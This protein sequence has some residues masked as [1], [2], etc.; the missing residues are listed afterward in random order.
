MPLRL[1]FQGDDILVYS[2]K[3]DSILAVSTRTGAVSQ[4]RGN[5]ELNEDS[6]A[7]EC[8][9]G[10]SRFPNGGYGYL[11]VVLASSVVAISPIDQYKIHKV[12]RVAL[13]PIHPLD[14]QAA[15]DVLGSSEEPNGDESEVEDP[16]DIVQEV[17]PSSNIIRRMFSGDLSTMDTPRT[18]LQKADSPLAN[19][20][21]NAMHALLEGQTYFSRS[22]LLQDPKFRYNQHFMKDIPKDFRVRLVQGF[23]RQVTL[24][25]AAMTLEVLL[26]SM[27]SRHRNGLRYQRRGIDKSGHVANFVETSQITWK[28]DTPA[29]LTFKQI[30]GS[31]PLHWTQESWSLHPIPL[32]VRSDEV[33]RSSMELHYKALEEKYNRVTS[34]SLVEQKGREGRVGQAFTRRM[35]HINRSLINYDFHHETSGMDYSKL[36]GL[37]DDIGQQLSRDAWST[38]YI[39]DVLLH[40][41]PQHGIIRTNC[42]DCLDRTNVVQS[43]IALAV[44]Q[45]Q[46]PECIDT[47]EE[48]QATFQSL[49]AD[50]G[51][52]IA[53]QYTN[54]PALKGDFTRTGKR[55]LRG[56]LNDARNA[57]RRYYTN[58]VRDFFGQLVIDHL[59]GVVD[60]RAVERFEASLH[61]E[62]MEAIVAKQQ[63]QQHALEISL[64]ILLGDDN[65]SLGAWTLLSP[66]NK[67]DLLS[68]LR[69]RQVILTESK[70]YVCEFD[71]DLDRVAHFI[72]IDL[73]DISRIRIG[74]YITSTVHESFTNTNS[75]YGFVIIYT[76]NIERMV[77]FKADSQPLANH[78]K[79]FIEEIVRVI[80]S[81]LNKESSIV[82]TKDVVGLDAHRGNFQSIMKIVEH[83]V[84]SMIW[85]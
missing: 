29:V 43:A 80:S 34:I 69:E 16:P 75:N 54:T 79:Q 64:R 48:C 27:R 1:Y 49:W 28:P 26:V 9:L 78:E 41:K 19:K 6:L 14:A 7:I 72:E 44:L 24:T 15:I 13:I 82:E 68:E 62:E 60:N 10:I 38:S 57:I 18:T 30:R 85:G 70:V 4:Y 25:T 22:V 51:D 20:F 12:D 37:V 39:D 73:S 11:I 83:K 33:N 59:L 74:P 35:S 40:D 81:L 77:A 66:S 17:P 32:I 36:S 71:Y 84:S 21:V 52:A 65:D 76:D 47:W 42:M 58:T 23:I 67:T 3:L 2:R 5:T 56:I 8:V 61:F 50:N 53:Q 45:K 55:E 31:I 63:L 46:Y